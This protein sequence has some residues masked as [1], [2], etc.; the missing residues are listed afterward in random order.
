MLFGAG[1]LILPVRAGT[2]VGDH[3]G[4][5]LLGFLLSAVGFPLLG[6]WGIVLFDG[7]YLRF[8]YRLGKP[9][10]NLIIAA[11][12][13]VVGPMIGIPRITVLLYSLFMKHLPFTPPHVLLAFPFLFTLIVLAI[14]YAMTYRENDIVRIFT[15]Y[16]NPLLLPLLI[17]IIIVGFLKTATTS[18]MAITPIS[19]PIVSLQRLLWGYQTLDLLAMLFVYSFTF[20]YLKQ[21]IR[22]DIALKKA[23]HNLHRPQSRSHWSFNPYTRVC[24][25]DESWPC[26]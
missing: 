7:D 19:P 22:I 4:I 9:V 21:H 11:C 6:L 24:W 5:G 15:H 12:M 2:L 14:V 18:F 20:S 23:F 26:L 16:I 8:F 1:N 10:G 17:F 25:Y 3:Y 13:L